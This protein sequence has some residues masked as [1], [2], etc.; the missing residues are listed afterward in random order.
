[1]AC[2]CNVAGEASN[3]ARPEARHRTSE[4][5]LCHW[6]SS[7]SREERSPSASLDHALRPSGRRR[8][9]ETK[10]YTLSA[11]MHHPN[12]TGGKWD[13]VSGLRWAESLGERRTAGC[14]F[15]T[16]RR[17]AFWRLTVAFR[18]QRTCAAKYVDRTAANHLNRTSLKLESRARL[19]TGSRWKPIL[20][21]AMAGWCR[22]HVMD[23]LKQDRINRQ[24]VPSVEL[25]RTAP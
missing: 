16:Q 14:P 10:A 21:P 24:H 25:R 6:E 8:R 15:G 7:R 11:A 23:Q 1:M 22:S 18:E 13:A 20:C 5:Y 4:R 3:A 9:S 12:L 17:H 2:A 19:F